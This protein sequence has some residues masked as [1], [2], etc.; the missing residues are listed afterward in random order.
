MDKPIPSTLQGSSLAP[1]MKGEN[2]AGDNVFIE[3]N[4]YDF[5][6]RW[7]RE[8][9]RLASEEEIKRAVSSRTRTIVSQD[10]WKLCLRD[11]DLPQLYNLND[12][13]YETTNLFGDPT[14]MYKVES[15]AR[16]I[17]EWQNETGDTV[18]IPYLKN[19]PY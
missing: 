16:E 1:I 3:W 11:K 13:P 18:G 5:Y 10:G 19:L 12:D 17:R 14:C 8:D 2:T 6:M 9:T 15:L 4:P 7:V